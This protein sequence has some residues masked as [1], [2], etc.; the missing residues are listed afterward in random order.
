MD[1]GAVIA[2]LL[3][4]MTASLQGAMQ[5]GLLVELENPHRQHFPH[6]A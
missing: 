3:T 2:R 1:E 4:S 5:V 6:A